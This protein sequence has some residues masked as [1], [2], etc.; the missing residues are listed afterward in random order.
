MYFRLIRTGEINGHA[1]PN[2]PILKSICELTE[3]ISAF[4]KLT[5]LWFQSKIFFFEENID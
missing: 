2:P 3:N 1:R 4:I 5:N